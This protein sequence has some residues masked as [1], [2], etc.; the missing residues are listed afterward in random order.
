MN[1]IDLLR[2]AAL[3]IADVRIFSWKTMQGK[4]GRTQNWLLFAVSSYKLHEHE[5]QTKANYKTSHDQNL[6]FVPILRSK[7]LY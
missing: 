1:M 5:E 2:Y 4:V 7:T 3:F 6:V